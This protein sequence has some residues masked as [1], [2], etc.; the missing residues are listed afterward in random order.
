M[1]HGCAQALLINHNCINIKKARWDRQTDIRLRH[2][3]HAAYVASI[4]NSNYP[5]FIQNLYKPITA[6]MNLHSITALDLRH[7]Y[8]TATASK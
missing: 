4:M 1:Y 2:Q 7:T 6:S 5:S 8:G 3:L